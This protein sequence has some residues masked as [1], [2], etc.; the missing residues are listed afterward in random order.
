MNQNPFDL[1]VSELAQQLIRHA[2][3]AAAKELGLLDNGTPKT[4][5]A[6]TPTTGVQA[7]SAMSDAARKR[8]SEAAKKR[9]REAK[10]AGKNRLG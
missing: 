6:R 10:K 4:R 7:K 9:W 1:A 3:E 8:M 2:K 5:K